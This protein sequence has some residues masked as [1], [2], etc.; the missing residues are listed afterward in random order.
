MNAVITLSHVFAFWLCLCIVFIVGVF[1]LT[2]FR[3]IVQRV[4]EEKLR[5]KAAEDA[6]YAAY[7]RPLKTWAHDGDLDWDD[8]AHQ[9]HFHKTFPPKQGGWVS[10]DLVLW[11]WGIGIATIVISFLR[12]WFF[13][14]STPAMHTVYCVILGA[15]F[16]AMALILSL[17][18]GVAEFMRVC[19]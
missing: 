1:L 3:E 18:W 2:L 16:C 4:R 12:E 11:F 19:A 13:S 6:S 10:G 17:V 9:A 15:F 7:V 8:P 5:R 14:S